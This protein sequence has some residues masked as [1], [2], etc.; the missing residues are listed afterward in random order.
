MREFHAAV[1]RGKRLLISA[2]GLAV[3]AVPVVFCLAQAKQE[4]PEWQKSAGGKMEFEVASIKPAVDPGRQPVFCPVGCTDIDGEHMTV[5]GSH[6]YIRYVSLYKLIDM[7]YHIR[8]TQLFGPGWNRRR[9]FAPFRASDDFVE[10]EF[11]EIR[12]R[13][14]CA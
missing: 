6:V 11:R 14:R 10:M 2:A 1:G 12:L 3:I 5:D 8:A 7:A 9:D 4:M 13:T